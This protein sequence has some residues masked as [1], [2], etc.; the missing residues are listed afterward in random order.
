[1]NEEIV[2]IL[3]KIR[4]RREL[5]IYLA[6]N[7]K[8]P[9]I[10]KKHFIVDVEY[11]GKIM[12]NSKNSNDGNIKN[13][14]RVFKLIEQTQ[15][16]KGE[17]SFVARYY[18]NDYE[19]IAG[20]SMQ[21]YYNFIILTSEYSNDRELLEEINDLPDYGASLKDIEK[22]E[23]KE[24]AKAIGLREEE[25]NSM[26]EM[27][28]AQ[29]IEEKEESKGTEE[30][31]D[32]ESEINE[33]ETKEI[34]NQKQEIRL[35]TRIDYKRTLGQALDLDTSEFTKV[36]VV[37]SERLKEIK[38]SDEKINNTRYSFVAIRKDG[39]ALDISDRLQV[40]AR[41]GNNQNRESIKVDADEQARKDTQTRTRFQIIGEN[42]KNA[43]KPDY[44]KETL[45]L[46]NSQYGEIKA[47][48][49]KGRSKE[50]QENIETQIKTTNVK[51]TKTELLRLSKESSQGVDKVTNMVKEA[52]ENLEKKENVG[53]SDVDGDEYTIE[54]GIEVFLENHKSEWAELIMEDP[55]VDDVF[56]KEE[57]EEMI[58]KY[59]LKQY[60]E[61]AKSND[62][63]IDREE[64]EQINNDIKKDIVQDA[65]KLKEA[66]GR[67]R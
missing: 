57:V 45:S 29:K 36:A 41:T 26:S 20:N 5:E 61:K 54:D 13:E 24:I 14:K 43:G 18:T 27:E 32:E 7:E 50:N 34:S 8:D 39:T 3:R 53:L 17:I 46:E 51:P 6:E 35:D 15:N 52:D 49:G 30:K 31:E 4:D 55:D 25:I 48:Y 23:L 2:E 64:V 60:S 22:G 40:D 33:E 65:E 16:E 12:M 66:Q 21:G 11:L 67:K 59:W 19:L 10:P 1:M 63:K 9:D 58:N 47:Y 42:G 37:Y 62:G 28:L 44:E 38:D 56:T